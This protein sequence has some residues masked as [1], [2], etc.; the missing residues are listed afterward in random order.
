MSEN[1][2]GNLYDN[3]V[4]IMIKGASPE[5]F[6]EAA[7]SIMEILSTPVADA[8]KIAAISA[9]KEMAVPSGPYTIS[10]CTV[11]T[12]GAQFPAGEPKGDYVFDVI[13]ECLADGGKDGDSRNSLSAQ[14]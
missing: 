3:R 10:G 9:I 1:E 2:T 7:K 14:R 13:R 11:M 5:R 8:V 6:V 12:E 4:G